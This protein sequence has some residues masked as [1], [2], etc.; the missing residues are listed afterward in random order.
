VSGGNVGVSGTVG[1]LQQ[2]NPTLLYTNVI[3]PFT[4]TTAAEAVQLINQTL[5]VGGYSS[6]LIVITGGYSNTT[7]PLNPVSLSPVLSLRR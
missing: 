5:V 6:L 7:E 1:A 2:A 4:F 3:T